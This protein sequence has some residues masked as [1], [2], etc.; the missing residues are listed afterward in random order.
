ME[1]SNCQGGFVIKR[2]QKNTN[3]NGVDGC[4]ER[5]GVSAPHVILHQTSIEGSQKK[6]QVNKTACKEKIRWGT[7]IHKMSTD[8][9]AKLAVVSV[10]GG[11]EAR[12]QQL[13]RPAGHL[14][15]RVNE[16]VVALQEKKKENA[17]RKKVK[18]LH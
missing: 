6:S 9:E 17:K 16:H 12:R 4:C 1:R 18:H 7:R 14:G 2:N 3:I 13:R 15:R 11:H 8:P 10:V 5:L